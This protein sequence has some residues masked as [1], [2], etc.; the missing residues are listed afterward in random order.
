MNTLTKFPKKLTLVTSSNSKYRKMALDMLIQVSLREPVWVLDAGNRFQAFDLARACRRHTVNLE[1]TLR[2]IQIA[3]A[4]TPY[5]LRTLAQK[6]RTVPETLFLLDCL[7]PFGAD[8]AP[9]QEQARLLNN[10]LQA[11]LKGPPGRWVVITAPEPDPQDSIRVELYRHLY[12][13]SNHQIVVKDPIDIGS[14]WVQGTLWEEA[15]G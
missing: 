10:I 1:S 13:R 14:H 6:M 8:I 3:R 2:R 5:H 12:N 15:D 9:Y 11:L 7:A 4:F